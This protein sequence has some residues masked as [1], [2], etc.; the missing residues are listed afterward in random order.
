MLSEKGSV[1]EKFN[2][3]VDAERRFV[4]TVKMEAGR[5]FQ[6]AA[7]VVRIMIFLHSTRDFPLFLGSMD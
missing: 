6:D 3:L 5:A 1:A 7:C 4:R 2:S